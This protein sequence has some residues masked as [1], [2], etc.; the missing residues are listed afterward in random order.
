M[1]CFTANGV[2]PDNI[3]LEPMDCYFGDRNVDCVTTVADT[4]LSLEDTYFLFET[5]SYLQL[6]PDSGIIGRLYGYEIVIFY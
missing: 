1:G 2:D 6:R 5:T 3:K 4:A